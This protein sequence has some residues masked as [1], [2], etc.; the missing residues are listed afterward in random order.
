M[1]GCIFKQITRAFLLAAAFSFITA[2]NALAAEQVNSGV[3]N[4]PN[5]PIV[6]T[7]CK[8]SRQS[9]GW[10]DIFGPVV[11]G[12]RTKHALAGV[13]IVYAFYDSENV[14]M[15]QTTQR[16]SLSEPVLSGDT[17]TVQGGASFNG[18]AQLLSRV[19]CRVQSADFSANK[20]WQYGQAWNEKLVPLA[21][22]QA[23]TPLDSSSSQV[24]S[25]AK[26]GPSGSAR[27]S[28][29]AAPG[30]KITSTNAWN[31]TVGGNLLV[32]VA[33]DV[34]GGSG[35]ATLSPANLMLT[36]ALANGGKKAY[37]AIPVAAPTFQ[38]LNPLGNTTTIA[39]EVDPKE[40]IG[41]LGSIIVPAHGS[42]K[43][44][45]TFLIGNDLVANANDN[46]NVVLK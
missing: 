32:H 16:Y 8:M 11:I 27:S 41:G 6:L 14:R 10:N 30:V 25:A 19:T 23:A 29:A 17:V 44:V 39:Y 7:A 35:D 46:R 12:N 33:I 9:S 5:S 26:A 2:S 18:T 15:S 24:L 34:E 43:L 4:V 20:R 21:T 3:V 38:K 45:A 13:Q 28:N 1:T 31:D 22:E 42:V 40:D 36:M 37:L